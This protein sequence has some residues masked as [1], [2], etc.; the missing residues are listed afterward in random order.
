[1]KTGRASQSALRV[2]IRRAA[3]QLV[4]RPPVLDDP[5]A[6]PLLG[7]GYQRD[8]ERAMH[9]VARDFRG[10][11]AARTRYVEDQLAH[12]VANAATQFVIP[13][14]VILGAGL[15]TF[16]YRNPFPSV[17]VFEVDF[18]ATQSWKRT[19]LSE[20]GIALPARLAFVPLD[21]ERQNLAEALEETGFDLRRPAFFSW[22]GMVPYLTIDAFRATLATV[23]GMPHGSGITFDYVDSPETLTQ[24][25]RKV[26]NGLA[27]K[28]AAAGEPLRLFLSQQQLQQELSSAGFNRI[29]HVGIE[30]LN[31]L[32]FDNRTDG[33]RLSP[34]GVGTLVS[35]WV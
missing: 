6:L 20:A 18:P 25:R 16:A 17:H 13:Q 24:P 28:L 5:I 9:R 31:E 3:H 12:A 26:F 19:K 21:L 1:M 30:R 22:L 8:L 11:M 32:Y 2:A 33:L 14:Y 35:A 4:D 27:K 34:S 29:E 15:D 23:G 10:F 7:S